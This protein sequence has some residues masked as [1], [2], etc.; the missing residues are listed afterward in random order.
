[1]RVFD[2]NTLGSLYCSAHFSPI[3]VVASFVLVTPRHYCYP[4]TPAQRCSFQ[5]VKTRDV[6]L[7]FLHSRILETM[8]FGVMQRCLNSFLDIPLDKKLYQGITL[9]GIA[10][11]Y[12]NIF[13]NLEPSRKI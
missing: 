12:G 10:S 1:M 4:T 7:K 3:A 13:A 9:Y 2:G 8:P 5:D 11:K 6:V